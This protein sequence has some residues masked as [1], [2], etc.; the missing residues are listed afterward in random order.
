MGAIREA[1]ET[2]LD[3]ALELGVLDEDEHAAVIEGA[4]KAANAL[5]EMRGT[6]RGYASV[7]SSY[8]NFCKALGIVPTAKK[9][10]P[11]IVGDGKLAK[12]RAGS[13]ASLRAV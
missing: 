13:R 10:Q 5:D 11:L 6:E 2:S 3:A 9:Q 1:L 7:L 12:M 4:R 8:L